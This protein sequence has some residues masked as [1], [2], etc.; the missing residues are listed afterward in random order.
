ML[1]LKIMGPAI[2]GSPS[3]FCPVCRQGLSGSRGSDLNRGILGCSQSRM[4]RLGHLDTP[5]KAPLH[6]FI[7]YPAMGGPGF[8]PGV[9]APKARMLPSYIIR[10]NSG[11]RIQTWGLTGYEPGVL[12]QTR[13]PRYT[14]LLTCIH[15]KYT[16]RRVQPRGFEPLKPYDAGS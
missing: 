2:I 13:P 9:R 6:A 14:Y 5:G 11:A 4:A 1:S 10:P 12:D 8:E 16:Y 15:N 3:W 7:S